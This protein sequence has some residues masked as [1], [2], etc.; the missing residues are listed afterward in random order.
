MKKIA[1]I[2]SAL[3][4]VMFLDLPAA[5]A[6]AIEDPIAFGVASGAP[7]VASVQARTTAPLSAGIGADG[8]RLSMVVVTHGTGGGIV[9]IDS[10]AMPGRVGVADVRTATAAGASRAGETELE[11]TILMLLGLMMVVLA[12][13]KRVVR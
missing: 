12:A 4:A 13:S 7:I 2:R 8:A 3:L 1:L 5:W 10:G 9:E 6:A 11:R